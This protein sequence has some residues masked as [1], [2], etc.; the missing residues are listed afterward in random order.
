M[1]TNKKE[2]RNLKIV[3]ICLG[4]SLLIGGLFVVLSPP[5]FKKTVVEMSCKLQG[6]YLVIRPISPMFWDAYQ[7]V[8]L[9]EVGATFEPIA[10]GIE[11]CYCP[12]WTQ[13]NNSSASAVM[14]TFRCETVY[15]PEV[16]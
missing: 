16:V 14:G 8:S 10:G 11:P 3:G 6:K 15:I 9:C 1:K 4:I 7:C 12:K 5:F 13:I 2:K